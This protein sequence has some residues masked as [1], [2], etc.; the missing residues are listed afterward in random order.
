MQALTAGRDFDASKQ[1]IETLRRSFG[2]PRMCIERSARQ[3]KSEHEHRWN[4]ILP[5]SQLAQ[6]SFRL[7]VEIIDEIGAIEP[8]AKPV[9]AL[10][11]LPDRHLEH[12]W[13]SGNPMSI[14]ILTEL[15][16]QSRE[17]GRQ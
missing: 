1:K 11:E 14:E 12:R 2:S 10:G 13:G 9:E 8:L 16:V 5:F 4:S 6:L 15:L 7:R 3:R 17:Y